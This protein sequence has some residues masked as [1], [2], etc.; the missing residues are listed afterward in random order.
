MFVVLTQPYQIKRHGSL[1]DG[2]APLRLMERL[3][4]GR[5]EYI[6]EQIV[7]LSTV[8]NR[9][10][11]LDYEGVLGSRV[12]A[13]NEKRIRNLAHLAQMVGECTTEFFLL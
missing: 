10:I 4:H 9:E 7:I 2:S 1:W 12:I 5:K 8:L 3:K 13:F 11:N 6:D